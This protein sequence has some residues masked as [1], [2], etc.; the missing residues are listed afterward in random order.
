MYVPRKFRVEDTTKLHSAMR[1]IAVATAV[2]HGPDGM[3][4]SQVPVEVDVNPA[5]FGT[6]RFHLTRANPQTA[7]FTDDSKSEVLLVFQGPQSYVTP[8]WYPSKYQTG[9]V[10]PTLNYVSIHAYGRGRIIDDTERLKEHLGRLTAHFESPFQ[11]KWGLDDAP[12]SYIDGMCRAII[13]VEIA[14]TRIDGK[15]KL[16]QNKSHTDQVGVTNGLRVQADENSLRMADL[17]EEAQNG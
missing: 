1:E 3:V 4:A 14:L 10:V 15:W 17:V 13:G 8:S 12:A 11:D 16:S 9:K 5:P 2:S 6:V 7:A